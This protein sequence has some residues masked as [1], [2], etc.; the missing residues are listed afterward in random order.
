MTLRCAPDGDPIVPSEQ[1]RELRQQGILAAKAGQ[2]EEARRLLQQAIRLEPTSETAWLWLASVARDVREREFCLKR[3]LELNPSHPQALQGMAA[4]RSQQQ[5]T[6]PQTPAATPPTAASAPEL[7]ARPPDPYRIE[8]E[9]RRAAPPSDNEIMSR[10]PGVPLPPAERLADAQRL[11]ETLMRDTQATPPANNIRWVRRARNR[12]GEGDALRWR[13]RLG[14]AT[15]AAVVALLLVACGLIALSPAAQLVVFGPSATPSPTPT[16]T[17]TPTPGLTP[18]PSPTPQRSPTASPTPPSDLR[19]A[20]GAPRPTALY[21]DAK[22]GSSF[23][24]AIHAL[25]RGD[26]AAALPVFT[27]ERVRQQE[28][29][30]AL[31][32]PAPYYYE[33]LANLQLGRLRSALIALDHAEDAM[34]PRTTPNERALIA[35][36]YAQAYLALAQQAHDQRIAS[37]FRDYSERALVAARRAVGCALSDEA[38]ATPEP[39]PAVCDPAL[40]APYLVTARIYAMRDSYAQ[41]LQT[42]DD[43]L[44]VDALSNNTLLLLEKG[45]IYLAQ[46]HFADAGQQAYLA[47]YVDPTSEGA[48]RLGITAS[49]AQNHPGDAVLLAQDW[50]IAYPGSSEAWR[51]LGDARAAEGNPDLA[52]VAYA[53][54]LQ[55]G[56]PA[57]RAAAYAARAAIRQ[58][59]GQ[60]SQALEDLDA[61]LELDDQPAYRAARLVAALDSAGAGAD[62]SFAD[63][64]AALREAD[65]LND[66]QLDALQ[67]RAQVSAAVADRVALECP[68]ETGTLS[69]A[70]ALLTAAA[71]SNALNASERGA[72]YEALSVVWLCLGDLDLAQSAADLALQAGETA[73]R[74]YWRGRIAEARGALQAALRDYE[75]SLT[76]ARLQPGA[77]DAP[78]VQDAAERVRRL[79]NESAIPEPN[80]TPLAASPAPAA[81][82]EPA[83]ATPTRSA[84]PTVPT[85]DAAVLTTPQQTPVPDAANA[86]IDP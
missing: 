31:F 9:Q 29:A 50:L 83:S 51:A 43:A 68:P 17:L 46:R 84:A 14:A 59:S 38:T 74:R 1:A 66:E 6:A 11:A 64:L 13:L 77:A 41:A 60:T 30:S 67:G 52:L 76:L 23:E 65:A 10:P 32:Q 78:S 69:Q 22:L 79:H 2:R 8:A 42:L 57:Q 33:A 20:N 15:A 53:Q 47:R 21:P 24:D 70:G 72:V 45:Q 35:S 36:G 73:A 12:A 5:P 7:P 58:A 27:A 19:P 56:P 85:S 44:A 80:S 48:Y 4:L 62:E 75:W 61:A 81:T 54:A 3:I 86:P 39:G 55:G 63:D 37:Q 16:F 40:A 82:T 28:N 71:A 34:T 49:L 18:T 25:E 26:A